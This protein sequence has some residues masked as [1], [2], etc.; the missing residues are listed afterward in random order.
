MTVVSKWGT[1]K[2]FDWEDDPPQRPDPS[3]KGHDADIARAHYDAR[4]QL[5]NICQVVSELPVMRGMLEKTPILT[6]AKISFVEM[7]GDNPPLAQWS[8]ADRE[9]H[10]NATKILKYCKDPDSRADDFDL[11]CIFLMLHEFRHGFQQHFERPHLRGRMA[12]RALGFAFLYGD[13]L[14]E[15]DANAFGLTG[16]EELRQTPSYAGLETVDIKRALVL[17]IVRHSFD[18][19][20]R[21]IENDPDAVANGTAQQSV[22]NSYFARKSKRLVQK[23]AQTTVDHLKKHELLPPKTKSLS[24]IFGEAGMRKEFFE[25]FSFLHGMPSLDRDGIL[26]TRDQYMARLP[27]AIYDVVQ[28]LEPDMLG[29]LGLHLP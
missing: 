16:L 2:L 22:I 10:L 17:S 19:F 3:L 7:S 18:I 26:H 1:C 4:R 6:Q 9:L 27:L 14:Y 20:E 11:N 13:L 12:A 28:N 25:T 23:Y 15:A 21:A 8:P 29:R 24:F 5:Y